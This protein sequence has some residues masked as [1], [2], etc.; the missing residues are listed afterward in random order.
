MPH[1]NDN[2]LEILQKLNDRYLSGDLRLYRADL[3]RLAGYSDDENARSEASAKTA[4]LVQRFEDIGL[5]ENISGVQGHVVPRHVQIASLVVEY[6]RQVVSDREAS[7]KETQ[8]LAD[9]IKNSRPSLIDR[10]KRHPFFALLVILGSVLVCLA[11][12]ATGVES[13]FSIIERFIN[14]V[15]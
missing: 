6:H 2:D 3:F 5:L 15:P 1:F 9:A 14:D 7:V 13:T 4:A 10:A 8:R 11:A 12:I